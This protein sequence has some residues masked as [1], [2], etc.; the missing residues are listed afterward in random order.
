MI[1]VKKTEL[2]LY[3]SLNFTLPNALSPQE[4]SWFS[5]FLSSFSGIFKLNN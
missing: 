5:N 4:V 1:S 3:N 2:E